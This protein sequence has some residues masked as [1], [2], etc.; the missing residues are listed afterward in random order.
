LS[1]APL[2]LTAQQL[3]QLTHASRRGAAESSSALARWL[4][5]PTTMTIDTVDQCPLAEATRLL[6]EADHVIC[7]CV[8]EMEGEFTGHMLLGFDEA[9]GLALSDLLLGRTPGSAAVFGDVETSCVLETMNIAGSAYLNGL[10]RDLTQRSGRTVELIP[11]TPLFLRDYAESLLQ[12]AFLDQAMSGSDA[13][14]AQAQFDCLG[15]PLH[16]T[17]LLI[18]DPPSLKRLAALLAELP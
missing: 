5:V 18:P 2:I 4:S 12:S 16:W 9:S 14:F 7:M 15:Q 1:E 10:A 11:A 13:V 8:M 6:G 3:E 17:F